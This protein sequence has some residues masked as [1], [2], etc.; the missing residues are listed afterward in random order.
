MF[1][2]INK[3]NS[4]WK[5]EGD[6]SVRLPKEMKTE[7]DYFVKFSDGQHAVCLLKREAHGRRSA[8]MKIIYTYLSQDEI[9][10]ASSLTILNKESETRNRVAVNAYYSKGAGTP[11]DGIETCYLDLDSLKD[12]QHLTT[13]LF[14]LAKKINDQN[15]FEKLLA[16][17]QIEENRSAFKPRK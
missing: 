13:V 17:I 14:F 1:R 15:V 3:N 11:A 2:S 12:K 10:A 5:Q 7:C 6:L 16:C 9:E 8:C 4:V